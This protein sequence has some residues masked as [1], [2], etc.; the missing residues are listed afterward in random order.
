MAFKTE[1]DLINNIDIERIQEMISDAV[2]SDF[3]NGVAWLNDL[4]SAE[5]DKRYPEIGKVLNTIMKIE[6]DYD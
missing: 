1:Q 4:A 5:F 3:E 2:Q 6:V